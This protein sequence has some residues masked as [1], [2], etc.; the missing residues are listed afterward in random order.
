MWTNPCTILDHVDYTLCIM[1]SGMGAKQ[2]AGTLN[3]L[4]LACTGF[5]TT[6]CS[7]HTDDTKVDI[8]FWAGMSI[9]QLWSTSKI[10][11]RQVLDIRME[12]KAFLT[13][14]LAKLLLK[15][16]VNHLL[17][18]NMQCLDPRLM[19]SKKELCVEKM[20]GV[21]PI[22]PWLLL[23]KWVHLWQS[24]TRIQRVPWCCISCNNANNEPKSDHLDVLLH[25]TIA[26]LSGWRSLGDVIQIL[27]SLGEGR[28]LPGQVARPS[29]MAEA[30]MQ[31]ANCTSGAIWGS[32]SCSRI[33]Q[34]ASQFSRS[35][36]LNQQP[37]LRF[38]TLFFRLAFR[39]YFIIKC[40]KN[41][42]MVQ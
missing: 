20:K 27:L 35:W 16:S 4:C 26:H 32:V 38:A 14:L 11:E 30:A 3:M 7:L 15:S 41:T 36:D 37:F 2:V 31:G 21:I 8:G 25:K 10:I 17:V 18:R 12:T 39:N 42:L 22:I 23:A 28:V 9:R 13:T 29:L 5:S 1:H 6:D 24:V 34:H 40:I 33:L 19:V